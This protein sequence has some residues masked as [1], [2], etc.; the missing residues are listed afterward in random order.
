M[1]QRNCDVDCQK[2]CVEASN[3]TP[4]NCPQY[5][6]VQRAT[7]S[8]LN[9]DFDQLMALAEQGAM[10]SRTRGIGQLPRFEDLP[11]EVRDGLTQE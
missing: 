2:G 6:D 9:L 4:Q 10:E 5:E 1:T 3:G 7:A 8:V 11:P